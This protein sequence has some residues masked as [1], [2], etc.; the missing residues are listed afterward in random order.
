MARA[1]SG[2]RRVAAPLQGHTEPGD[3][4]PGHTERTAVDP[5]PS[6]ESAAVPNVKDRK[7][8][9]AARVQGV[10]GRGD[11]ESGSSLWDEFVDAPVLGA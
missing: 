2:G 1:A 6:A 3:T 8:L 10:A 5:N 9:L 11:R 7:R 4:E